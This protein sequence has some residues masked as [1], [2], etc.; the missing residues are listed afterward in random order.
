[1]MTIRQFLCANL[2]L[3]ISFACYANN[4]DIYLMGGGTVSNISNGSFVGINQYMVNKYDTESRSQI[5]P[6]LGAG[7]AHTFVPFNKPISLSLGLSGYYANFG[8]IKGTEYPFAND[9]VFDSLNYQFHAQAFS[10]MLESRLAYT[11]Y[12]WQP[13]GIIGAG[14]SWNRLNSYNETPTI[15]SESASSSPYP[16]ANHT[17]ASFAYE[18]GVGVQKLVFNDPNHKLQYFL[19]LEY[20]YLNFGKGE[21]GPSSVQ[22][23]S[24]RLQV[25]N[26]DAQ[27]V[28]L[29]LKITV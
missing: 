2:L 8:K 1:M 17:N 10:A 14:I 28:L 23:S 6:I 7:I 18:L 4:L 24:N 25:S 29:S 11:L 21:L 13:Y 22:T 9:G 27:S 5:E 3:I 16:F 26:L 19:S 12:D 20:R 15:P